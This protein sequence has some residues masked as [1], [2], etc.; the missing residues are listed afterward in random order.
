MIIRTKV[1]ATCDRAEREGRK[2]RDHHCLQDYRRTKSSSGME[3][4][5][6]VEAFNT[7][8]A[9][10]GLIY[11]ILIADGDS[12]VYKGI[13]DANPYK[14]HNIMVKKFGCTC[15]ISKNLTK[16]LENFAK[17]KDPSEVRG[18]SGLQ[19][20]QHLEKNITN[21]RYEVLAA[22]TRRRIQDIT[23]LE[24]TKLLCD[25]ISNVVSHVFGEHKEC[26][27]LNWP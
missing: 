2:P 26:L 19:A 20:R 13:L 17:R 14:D 7:S 11:K 5:A 23:M 4:D 18:D 10:Y 21:I 9:K 27:R 6:L 25:D 15:H 16:A 12:S 22:A 24:K 3:K 8:I 1:C